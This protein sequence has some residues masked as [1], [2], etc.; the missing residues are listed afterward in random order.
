MHPLVKLQELHRTSSLEGLGPALKQQMQMQHCQTA[1]PQRCVFE[2]E[3]MPMIRF[4][5]EHHNKPCYFLGLLLMSLV[6]KC[7]TESGP[8]SAVDDCILVPLVCT[9]VR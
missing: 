4:I 2:L 1:Q 5:V 6:S 9:A 8:L 3:I 7:L